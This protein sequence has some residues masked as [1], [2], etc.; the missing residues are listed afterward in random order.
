M[1]NGAEGS[2]TPDLCSAIAALSQ[3]SYSP[4]S[5]VVND[6]PFDHTWKRPR[7]RGRRD[8]T[9]IYGSLPILVK[10]DAP[11]SKG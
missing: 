4:A 5:D 7:E 2:R 11:A 10:L 6:D 9:A 3:L 8:C 1:P